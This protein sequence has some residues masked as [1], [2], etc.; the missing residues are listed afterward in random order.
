MNKRMQP[1]PA[2]RKVLEAMKEGGALVS[3]RNY[4]STNWMVFGSRVSIRGSTA[5]ALRCAG[6]IAK[7]DGEYDYMGEHRQ[8]W[9]LTPMGLDAI[10]QMETA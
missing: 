6:W 10:K 3:A 8:A 1:T 4:A 9:A 5:T 2:Q 7:S